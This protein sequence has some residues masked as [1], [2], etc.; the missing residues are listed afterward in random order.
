MLD[1]ERKRKLRNIM[2]HKITLW[3]LG[4][5]VIFALHSTWL[6][7][8]KKRES[9]RMKNISLAHVRELEARD[10]DLK[11]KIERLSTP[12]GVEEEVRSKFSVAKENENMVVVVED[13]KV[14]ATTTE[15]VSIWQ[16][17]WDFI[18]N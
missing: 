4:V 18:K 3:V 1:F 17:I 8:Q 9:E 15:K 10:A 14:V 2:Y 6:V 12:T 5:V 11:S 7:Y 16:K 13:K